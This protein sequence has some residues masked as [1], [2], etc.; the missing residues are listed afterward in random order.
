MRKTALNQDF[1][2]PQGAL[3]DGKTRSAVRSWGNAAG[4]FNGSYCALGICAKLAR[5]KVVNQ[6]MG[7][8]VTTDLVSASGDL[9]NQAPVMLRHPAEHEESPMH[10]VPVKHVQNTPSLWFYK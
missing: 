10:A 2:R 3:C 7:E 5:R 6:A 4:V 8:A 1:K 9:P